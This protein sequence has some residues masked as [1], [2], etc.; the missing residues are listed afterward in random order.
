MTS[1]LSRASRRA[2]RLEELRRD[3]LSAEARV[4]NARAGLASVRARSSEDENPYLREVALALNAIGMIREA[5]D[6][7]RA[8]RD[9]HD[10]SIRWRSPGTLIMVDAPD[11]NRFY[12]KVPESE[13]A[14]GNVW[15]DLTTGDRVDYDTASGDV[16]DAG[17]Y[18]RHEVTRLY[19]P[20]H[21][22][23]ILDSHGI[24]I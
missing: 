22:D 20:D 11:G 17:R 6:K 4:E 24:E 12:E 3:E 9:M 21:V 15:L 23:A 1:S 14:V 5:R 13:S 7:I 18:V 10:P 8:E 16:N 19:T 2:A